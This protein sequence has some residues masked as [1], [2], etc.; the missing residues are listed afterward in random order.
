MKSKQSAPLR[1]SKL[2]DYILSRRPDEFGL[3]P[4]LNG[5][6]KIK[7]LLKAI[8]E[9]SG[10]GSIRQ[11][12]INEV[13]LSVPNALF[14]ENGSLIRSLERSRLPIRKGT[15]ELPKLL[16]TCVRQRAY[17]Y[18]LDHGVS[19]AGHFEVI[20][21]DTTAM[22]ERIGLRMDRETVL[23]TVQTKQCASLG[24]IFYNVGE[25]L[26]TAAAIPTGGFTGPPLPK[27]LPIE[28]PKSQPGEP[29]TPGSYILNLNN[30]EDSNFQVKKGPKSRQRPTT[31]KGR[32]NRDRFDRE[33]PPWRR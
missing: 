24:V 16:Y 3:V 11:S 14:E 20:L 1:L 22:A 21:A 27:E 25:G 8:S 29:K 18:V 4:D 19:P 7:D 31:G 28:R 5:F 17:P 13:L 26:Y 32:K 15:V 10:W 30:V 2:L 12:N 6:I 33:R 23:L 9:E